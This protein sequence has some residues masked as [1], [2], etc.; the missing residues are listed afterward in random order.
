MKIQRAMYLQILGWLR[1]SWEVETVDLYTGQLGQ[2][3]SRC[4]SS[5]KLPYVARP[6]IGSMGA[7]TSI[8]ICSGLDMSP[9][10]RSLSWELLFILPV[11]HTKALLTLSPP[12]DADNIKN[13]PIIIE[14][15]MILS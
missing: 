15:H 14:K 2:Y 1:Y 13:A 5:F 4:S 6:C 11:K 8:Y 9:E 7:K 3:S 10:G 12:K